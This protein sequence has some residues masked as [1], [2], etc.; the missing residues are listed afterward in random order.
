VNEHRVLRKHEFLRYEDVPREFNIAEY[1]VDRNL[2]DRTALITGTGQTTYAELKAMVNRT[3]NALRRLGVRRGDRVLLALSDGVEFV[4]VWYGAQKIGAVTAEVYTFLQ[5]KDYKYFLDYATPAVVVADA[6]TVDRLREAGARKLV[7]AGLP[8]EELREGESSLDALLAEESTELTAAP[9]RSDDVALWR[10]T[11]GSTGAPKACVIPARSTLLSFDW[12][13]RGI[14]D[15]GPD[16]IVLPVPKLFFGYSNNMA[17]LFPFGAGAAGI[18][19]PERSTV[20]RIFELIAR[21]RP[22]I[23]VNVPTMMSAMLAHPDAAAQDLSSVRLCVSGGELLPVD[24]HRTFM[25]TF[26][27]ETIDGIGSSE[28][29]HG[30]VS[31]RPGSSRPG[32]L[33]QALPGYRVRVVGQDDAE[34]P[35]GEVGV[36]EVT[37]ETVALEYWQEPGKSAET[38][39]SA[40]TLRS[41]DLASRDAEGFFYYRGR[42]DDLLK[43]GGVWVAP[44]EI[45]KCLA[46]HPSVLECAV[47]DYQ[48]GGLTR[49]RAFVVAADEVTKPELQDFVRSTLSPHKYPRDVRFLEKLPLTPSGKVDRGALRVLQ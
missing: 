5:P 9:T 34:V 40:H 18:V 30:F 32:S 45:E 17:V 21:H 16:D 8:P 31:N 28:S 26:G 36:L 49:T 15:L 10:F 3:G 2:G 46:A 25:E 29:F 43:V 39:P 41:G 48:V 23:L 1:F 42:A 33:G 24:L 44:T 20:D 22:T 38:F 35:D 7:V 6:V 47:V 4:S 13:A 14:M 37:G 27:V 12:Y 19:F 11:T